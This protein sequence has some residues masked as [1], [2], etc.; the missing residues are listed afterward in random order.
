MPAHMPA[1]GRESSQA[2]VAYTEL[3]ALI[4]SFQLLPG[5]ALVER[6]LEARLGSSR[7]PVRAALQQLETESLVRRQGRSF[8]V[9]PLDA[10]ELRQAFAFR[11]VLETTSA[12]LACERRTRADVA[13]L[14]KLARAAHAAEPDERH[15]HGQAFHVEIAGIAGNDFVTRTLRDIMAIVFRAR[16]LQSSTAEGHRLGLREYLEIVRAIDRRRGDDAAAAVERHIVRTRDALLGLLK[17]R[18]ASPR[19][20]ILRLV[21]VSL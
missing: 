9:A 3:R 21:G 12:R 10:E 4:L 2:A 19:K 1:E 5:E 6:V 7:T 20:R 15:H 11:I 13:R 14:M 18:E 17:D 8:I 16:W